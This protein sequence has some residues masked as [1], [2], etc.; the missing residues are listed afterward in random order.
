[1][2]K[3]IEQKEAQVLPAAAYASFVSYFITDRDIYLTFG[4]PATEGDNKSFH[5]VSRVVMPIKTAKE[6]IRA[7]GE[8]VK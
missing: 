3:S 8:K 6:L 5:L 1:M 2:K 4:Q 7:L